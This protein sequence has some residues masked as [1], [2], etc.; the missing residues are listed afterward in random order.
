M[1]IPHYPEI[2]AHPMD[3][4]E[5]LENSELEKEVPETD[6]PR[7][8]STDQFIANMRLVFSNCVRFNG[9]E[10][11]IS[12]MGRR[13]EEMFDK[14]I[15]NVLPP[16]EAKPPPVKKAPPAPASRRPSTSTSVIRRNDSSSAG[17]RRPK[18]EI[19]PPPSKDLPYADV[20]NK[21]RKA[22]AA[23]DNLN[24]EQLKFCSNLLGDL[25]WKQHWTIASPFYKPIGGSGVI[26]GR[27]TNRLPLL[28]HPAN[29]R[30]PLSPQRKHQLRNPARTF[31]QKK[32][33]S[34]TIQTFDCQK[35]VIQIILESVPEIRDVG[36]V[37]FFWICV[38]R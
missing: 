17:G 31:E 10:H 37:A 8:L 13:L 36:F 34:E 25:H 20:S 12:L 6:Q 24:S 28:L 30:R 11:M 32:D 7:Y 22:R 29:L 27:T 16:E 5:K 35:L 1:N 9:P 21:W 4:K 23:K 15:K 2:I 19:H 14:S 3:Y 18:R 26:L 38:C 33:L